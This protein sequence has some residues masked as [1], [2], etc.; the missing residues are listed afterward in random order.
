MV[1]DEMTTGWILGTMSGTSADAIDLALIETDGRKI[2]ALGPTGSGVY[3]PATRQAVLDLA[4][5]GTAPTAED[6]ARVGEMVTQD[7]LDAIRGFLADRSISPKTVRLVGFHGQTVFH[8]PDRSMTVQLGD[9]A[10]VASALDCPVVGHFRQ[11]DLAAGGQ[12]APIA[13]A[14]HAALAH[15]LEKPVAILNIG[16]VSNVTLL[17]PDMSIH[18]A[19]LGPGNAPIDDW[20]ARHTGQALDIDGKH[21]AAGTANRERVLQAL[22]HPYLAKPGPKSLDRSDFGTAPADGLSLEDGAATLLAV[23][24]GAI[25]KSTDWLPATPTRWLVTGGGRH[26]PT[27]MAALA[28]AL[29]VPVEPVE[30]VGWDGDAL[31]AQAMA[32]LAARSEAGL[33]TTWPTT[34]G[35]DTPT[36]GGVR[37]VP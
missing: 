16:G 29:T 11:A 14:Y 34:T 8:D 25:A 26:N 23:T 10:A 5:A 24:V 7:H 35:C 2:A 28:A 37:Y 3:R 13:P 31:E 32:Y 33:A 15:D 20:V 21:A 19:D 18:A 27:L 6:A 22:T 9:P 36:T 30:A 1:R 17:T 12:G 4:H